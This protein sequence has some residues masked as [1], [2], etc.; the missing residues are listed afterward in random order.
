MINDVLHGHGGW[1][2]WEVK[3]SSKSRPHICHLDL[4]FP[5]GKL[6]FLHTS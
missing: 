6:L 2:G 5:K 3:E 1:K 4:E